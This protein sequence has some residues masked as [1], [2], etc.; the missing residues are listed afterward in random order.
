[1]SNA[2]SSINTCRLFLVRLKTLTFLYKELKKEKEKEEEEEEKERAGDG[3][4]IVQI[5]QPLPCWEQGGGS[6]QAQ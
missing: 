4:A 3:L 6:A 2:H 1:M 5:H